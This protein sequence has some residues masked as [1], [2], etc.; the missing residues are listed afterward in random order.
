MGIRRPD[1]D[2]PRRSMAA[3]HWSFVVCHLLRAKAIRLNRRAKSHWPR[4]TRPPSCEPGYRPNSGESGYA[5]FPDPRLR[6]R[7]R[8][9]ADSP[10]DSQK[11]SQVEYAQPVAIEMRTVRTVRTVV[12]P[13]TILWE[14]KSGVRSQEQGA[15]GPTRKPQP[16]WKSEGECGVGWGKSEG[17][18]IAR[19]TR[20]KKRLTYRLTQKRKGK[21][22]DGPRALAA[23]RF[24]KPAKILAPTAVG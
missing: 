12:S 20:M 23:M 19:K 13:L 4:V 5:S 16:Q 1:D 14:Q 10:G 11:R 18:R 7:M 6:G 15:G 17:P 24:T 2:G 21:C 3:R 22:G 8:T 9:V